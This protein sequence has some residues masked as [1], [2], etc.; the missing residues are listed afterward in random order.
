MQHLYTKKARS[1]YKQIYQIKATIWGVI[2]AFICK[3]TCKDTANIK[4]FVNVYVIYLI[5]VFSEFSS[6]G[7]TFKTN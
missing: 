3:D 6:K 7:N 2:V 5:K 1:F 4:C